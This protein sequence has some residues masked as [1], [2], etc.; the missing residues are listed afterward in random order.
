MG[1][2]GLLPN[3]LLLLAPATV[4]AAGGARVE[5]HDGVGVLIGAEA[6]Y[7]ALDGDV[8]LVFDDRG[9]LERPDLGDAL[10]LTPDEVCERLGR[11]IGYVLPAPHP[12][13][14]PKP[15]PGVVTPPARPMRAEQHVRPLALPP[16][17]GRPLPRPAQEP[18]PIPAVDP[19]DVEAVGA[20]RSLGATPP[21]SP[22]LATAGCDAA[23]AARPSAGALLFAAAALGLLRRKGGAR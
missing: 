14:D 19:I 3:L 7:I 21:P 2:W 23:P 4:L 8:Y 17:L 22:A 10:W 1:R 16:G 12:G 15:T 13:E 18:G 5:C 6:G 11:G 20:D 9:V